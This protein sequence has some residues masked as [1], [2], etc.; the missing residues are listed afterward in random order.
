SRWGGRLCLSRNNVQ[1]VR[2]VEPGLY[3]ACCQNGLGTAKG[4]IAG[5]LAAEL[6]SG[7]QSPLLDTF[8]ASPAPSALPAAPLT[9][10]G[11]NGRMRWGEIRAGQD[12]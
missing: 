12:L 4:T 3:S 1:I 7:L 6:A 2:E 9:W 8:I 5:K 11:A 10:L